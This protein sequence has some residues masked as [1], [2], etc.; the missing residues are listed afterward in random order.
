MRRWGERRRKRDVRK[1]LKAKRDKE[2]EEW[3]N[4]RKEI[5]EKMNNGKQFIAEAFQRLCANKGVVHVRTT[6]HRPATNGIAERFIERLKEMLAER[7]WEDV[8]ELMRVLE[9]VISATMMHAPHQGLDALSPNE[10]ERRLM[11]VVS[12]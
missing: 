5:K 11:C 12:G 2:D 8:E 9:E 10:Y 6:R 3:R 7:E 1:E 4:K